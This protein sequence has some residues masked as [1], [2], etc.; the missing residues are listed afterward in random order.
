ML[1]IVAEI[2]ARHSRAWLAT[3]RG[4]LDCDGVRV[5]FPGRSYVARHYLMMG[6]YEPDVHAVASAGIS[7]GSTVFDVGANIGLISLNLLNAFPDIKIVSFEPSPTVSKHLLRTNERSS[8]RAR[9]DIVVKAVT[10]R[11]GDT[12]PFTVHSAGGDVFDGINDTG[13][14]LGG[15]VI[16]VPTTSLDTEWEARSRPHV[17]VIK[18]DVEGA[19][20]G[21][22]FGA[23]GCIQAC[24]PIV[25][26]E[27]FRKNYQVYSKRPEEMLSFARSYNYNVYILP[28]LT[29]ILTASAM[30]YATSLRDNFVLIP[31]DA[32]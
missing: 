1:H 3:R 26:T 29:P 20:L 4:W 8:H 15:R 13:R 31:E 11:A 9:W 10:E 19:E 16:A 27:W 32:T 21:V 6:S 7:A 2:L 23:A 18:V 5:Y 14:V 30:R 28:E 22:L 24:R 25:I 12:I 17:S